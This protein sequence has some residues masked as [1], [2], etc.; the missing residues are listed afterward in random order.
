MSRFTCETC[1]RSERC[2]L[3]EYFEEV[4]EKL[5]NDAAAYDDIVD[6][7]VNCIHHMSYFYPDE[8]E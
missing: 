2:T 6:V 3:Q 7:Y 1:G 4:K 5:E 8:S